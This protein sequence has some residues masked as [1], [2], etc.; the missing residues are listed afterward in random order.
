MKVRLLFL[1]FTLSL[2][3]LSA[4][5]YHPLLEKGKTWNVFYWQNTC[6]V[7]PCGGTQYSLGGDTIIQGIEY[8]KI[9]QK[10]IIALE[11]P[12][13]YLPF[14]LSKDSSIISFMRED[15]LNKKVYAIHN[16]GYEES[17]EFLAYNFNLQLGD[18]L[19]IPYLDSSFLILDTIKSIVLTNGEY[20]KIY[21]FKDYGNLFNNSQ[22]QYIEGIG[23]DSGLF[24]PFLSTIE[25]SITLG[26][27]RQ[28]G[29]E[30][31]KNP[32]S[33]WGCETITTTETIKSNYNF[34]IFP[35][36]VSN[37]LNINCTNCQ[38]RKVE[39]IDVNGNFVLQKQLHQI[40]NQQIDIDY[41]SSGIYFIKLYGENGIYNTSKFIK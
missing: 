11:E 21:L 26:C 5:N 13:F 22:S 14:G 33:R 27:V 6:F 18:S 32:N 24:F 4:Q 23:G 38:L 15:T 17:K 12:V 20:R 31:Y 8:K 39:I 2:Y 19:V 30:L 28:N 7:N 40:D 16:D 3:F 34:S 36:P 1:L 41:L 35:N 25:N 9:V 10:S 29:I 37:F